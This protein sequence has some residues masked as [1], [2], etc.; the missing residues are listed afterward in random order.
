MLFHYIMTGIISDDMYVY[1]V[2]P[3]KQNNLMP[4]SHCLKTANSTF[5][6][7]YYISQNIACIR[8]PLDSIAIHQ[9]MDF[10]CT[11]GNN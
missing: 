8:T 5:F 3:G 9:E 4:C 11:L 10:A 6:V 1:L 2:V 7:P